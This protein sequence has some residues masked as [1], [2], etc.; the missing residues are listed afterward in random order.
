MRAVFVLVL[1]LGMA[2]AGAAVYMIQDYIAQTDALLKKERDF[3]AK[4]GKLV[5]VYVF[6]KQLEYGDALSPEDVQ[7][8]YWPEKALPE[9]IFREEAV[10]FPEDA[11]GPRY[12]M[13]TTEAFE[14]VLASRVTE[15]G[16]LAGLTAKLESGMRAFAI[17]VGVASGVSGFVQPDD[18]ID[19]Y[20]TGSIPGVEGEVTQLIESSIQ[21]IAVNN[22]ISEEQSIGGTSARTITI[23]GTPE[24]V[25]RLA[26][27]QATGRLAMS[28]VGDSGDVT[29]EKVQV[30]TNSVLGIVKEEKVVAPEVVE[31][32]VCYSKQ[33]KGGE[34]VD[35][36]IVIPC[37]N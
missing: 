23:A 17:K 19:I 31:E 22:S 34:L 4:A 9:S 6:N 21:I 3:N 26:Q 33:R 28:L 29:T 11:D 27:A 10:L 2:L 32:E 20:W 15:P 18:F 1:V 12:I 8:I 30:D 7:L 13:R 16:Q 35:T 14:P 5:E 24:Q 25:A 36:N 37:N